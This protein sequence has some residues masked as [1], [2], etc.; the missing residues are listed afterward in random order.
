MARCRPRR[1]GSWKFVRSDS[2][3]DAHRSRA[4]NE[5]EPRMTPD[6]SRYKLVIQ[7][8]ADAPRT[9][10]RRGFVEYFDLGAAA[11]TNGRI[12]AEYVR[13]FQPMSEPTGWHY[14]EVEAQLTYV[15]RGWVEL[16]FE[17]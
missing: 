15:M 5:G 10:G 16:E 4:S 12:A 9:A 14:H 2:P 11:A 17:D 6:S 8:L 1:R 13:T 3:G 7:P